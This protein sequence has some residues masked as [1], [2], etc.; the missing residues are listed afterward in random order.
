VAAKTSDAP[1]PAFDV[2]T[3]EKSVAELSPEAQVRVV[4]ARLKEL[5][6]GYDG[7]EKHESGHGRVSR[8]ELSHI[9]LRDLS[10]LRALPRLTQLDLSGTSVTDLSPLRDLKLISLSCV[11]MKGIDL[12]S[13]KSLKELKILSLKS[14]PV[15]DLAPLEAWNS[16]S[17]TSAGRRRPISRRSAR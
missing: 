7:S 13:L 10:P 1:A 8:L 4:V 15:R 9:A 11:G 2:A 16:G 3:W 14:S 6:P 17:S 5:N 12:R